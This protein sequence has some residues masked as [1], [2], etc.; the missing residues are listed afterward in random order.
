MSVKKDL[1]PSEVAKTLKKAMGPPVKE[2]K[3]GEERAEG[4][5]VRKS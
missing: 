2:K 4:S 1:V 5:E 3:A